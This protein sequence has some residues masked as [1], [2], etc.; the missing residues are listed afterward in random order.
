MMSSFTWISAE[1][2]PFREP[3][4]WRAIRGMVRAVV[5]RF[6]AVATPKDTQRRTSP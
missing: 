4:C 2:H 6:D 1:Q 3:L 5:D